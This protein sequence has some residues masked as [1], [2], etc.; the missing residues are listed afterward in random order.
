[1]QNFEE[2]Y[3]GIIVPKLSKDI[4]DSNPMRVPRIEKVVINMGV[5][6]AITDNKVME[7]VIEQLQKIAGQKPIIT[8]AK[9]SLAAFKLREGMSIGCKVT[10]RKKK[11]YSFLERLITIVLPSLRDFRGFSV[12]NFDKKGNFNFG[13]KSQ[14]IFP[15][16]NYDMV[17]KVRGMDIAIVTSAK[18][19]E[20]A[21]LLLQELYFPFRN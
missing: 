6:D 7:K 9:K 11:M 3:E 16:I 18:S 19:D 15:E 8:K 4:Y 17:D 14:I 10:L 2:Y 21:K 5:A 12:N 20:D 13:L 1:M